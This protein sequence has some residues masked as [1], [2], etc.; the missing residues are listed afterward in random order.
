M[1]QLLLDDLPSLKARGT[2][3][4]KF[5]QCWRIKVAILLE[6]VDS[7]PAEELEHR[8]KEACILRT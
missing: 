5:L 7:C 3:G 8:V 4:R 2:A 1:V 6:I